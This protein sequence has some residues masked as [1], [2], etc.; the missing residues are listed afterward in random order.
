MIHQKNSTIILSL[1]TLFWAIGLMPSAKGQVVSME[2][3]QNRIQYEQKKWFRYESTN[4]YLSYAEED[5]PL[6]RYLLPVVELDYLELARMFEHQLKKRIEVI[7]YSDYSDYLQSNIGMQRHSVNRGGITQLVTPKIEVYFDG[8]H[9]N[10]RKQLRKGLAEVLL[11]KILVGTNLQEMVQNSVLMNLPQWFVKGAIAHATE[12]WNTEMDDRLRDILLSGKYENFVE[13]AKHEPLLAGQSLFHFVSQEHSTSTVSNLLY[14]T[15]INRSVENGFLYVFGKTYYQVVGSDWFNYYSDRYNK[16]NKK[17]RF[18]NKGALE[19]KIPK[20]ATIKN[21]KISPNSK[22]I[23]Y[24]EHNK[25][26]RKVIVY[27]LETQEQTVLYKHGEYDLSGNYEQHYPLIAWGKKSDKVIII[28]EK[29]DKVKIRYQD[30]DKKGAKDR[31]LEDIE[32]VID[33]EVLNSSTLVFTGFHNGHSD[34]YSFNGGKPRAITNDFW[35]EKELAIV[36]LKGQKGIVFS[37]NRNSSSLRAMHFTNQL[38]PNNFDLY[39]YNLTTKSNELIRLTRTP[40]ANECYP[41][42]MGKGDHF[43]YLSDENGFYNRYVAVVDTVLLREERVLVFEDGTQMIVPVDTV[44]SHLPVDSTY[45]QPVY[46]ETGVAHAN[47]DYSRNIL[48]HDGNLTKIVDLIYRKGAYHIFV[49]DAKPQRTMETMAKTT[50]RK[51]LEKINGLTKREKST[52]AIRTPAESTTVLPKKLNLEIE[53]ATSIKDTVPPVDTGKIDIDNYEFQ[54]EFED[55]TE[56]SIEKDD[57]DTEVTPIILVEDG[58][59][60]KASPAKK[61]QPK[62]I[63]TD[64]ETKVV[65]WNPTHTKRYKSLFKVDQITFQMDNTP[66]YNGMNMYLGGYYQ[67][68]PLSFALKT[69]FVDIFENFYLELGIR[70]PFDFNGMEYFVNV[71]NKKGLIDQKY[72]FYRRGRIN[73]YVVVDT[74]T[75]VA[76]EARGRTVKHLLQTELKYPLTKFQSVRGIFS[77]QLDKVAIL[78]E[79]LNSLQVPVYH[80]N[81]FGFRL[82]YVFD[83]SLELRHNARKGT[84]FRGYLDLYKPFSVQTEGQFKVGFEGG[85]TAALGF[86]ARHY[87][88]FDDKTIFAFRL[89]GASSFGQQ[90]ILYSLGGVENWM[91]PTASSTV[92]LPEASDYGLQTLAANMRGFNNNARNGSSYALANVEIRVPIIDYISKNPPRNAMLR[93][94]QLV[95]FLDV[96]TAWQ[97]ASPFSINNPLNTSV[98]DNNSP[99]QISPVKVTVNY[100]RRPILVGYGFGIRTVLLG[101]YFRLDYAWGVETGQVQKPILYLS[102]GAD[103]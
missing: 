18:P 8:N 42:A 38:P 81:R 41:I 96:G 58:D 55:I 6:A 86:D 70:I 28:H 11:G 84:K 1:F 64:P 67:F 17:R 88:T 15:R 2:Y 62:A 57:P 26:V 33:F 19:L 93:S 45:I 39:F 100:Y 98:I 49:R 103:F 61:S 68:Q 71:E 80:E 25:G 82:E 59:D 46:I 97:G 50:Y 73:T 60:I 79:E 20:T 44:Y 32:R 5:E 51:L 54:S 95:A 85:L 92:S 77:L 72:S 23:A 37:S 31:V 16:D 75:N 53:D 89:A 94:L 27:D 65:A 102:I 36:T 4:F 24:T 48:E 99:G 56:P 21:V 30:I 87:L 69:G 13:L 12:D 101:H 78:A 76:I 83:N 91:F 43:T 22:Y 52:A 10:L 9:A 14:L 7:I 47:T 74:T 29:R 90:K 66:M 63:L 34:L 35:D 40:L 3:G